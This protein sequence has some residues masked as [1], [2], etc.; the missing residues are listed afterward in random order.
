[1]KNPFE[2][3]YS[4]EAYDKA[5]EEKRSTEGDSLNA[6]VNAHEGIAYLTDYD[7]AFYETAAKR[8]KKR[9]EKLGGKAYTEAHELQAE[10]LRLKKQ[11]EDSTRAL[12][13]FERDELDMHKKDGN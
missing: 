1:M 10:H 2:K 9:L 6:H 11:A 8:A 3:P 13:E 7:L 5:D 4:R 12:Y